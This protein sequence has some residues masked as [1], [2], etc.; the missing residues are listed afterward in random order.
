MVSSCFYIID[1]S[2]DT[3]MIWGVRTITTHKG[4]RN[5]STKH[6]TTPSS[7]LKQDTHDPGHTEKQ[8]HLAKNEQLW[9]ICYLSE[10]G[11]KGEDSP[12]TTVTNTYETK[13]IDLIDC[14]PQIIHILLW[15]TVSMGFTTKSR[16]YR[17]FYK[18][19]IMFF[20]RRYQNAFH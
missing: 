5:S 16:P 19:C 1:Q 17:V 8:I 11:R 3:F 20:K 18:A 7:A 6:C 12:I 10:S 15:N 4:H 2:L 9:T 13:P 14:F